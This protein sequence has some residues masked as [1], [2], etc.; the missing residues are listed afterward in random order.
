[1]EDLCASMKRCST[2]SPKDF[3]F[4]TLWDCLPQSQKRESC[5]KQLPRACKSD[6]LKPNA[7]LLKMAHDKLNSKT[8]AK[9]PKKET[10]WNKLLKSANLDTDTQNQIRDLQ[11]MLSN[12]IQY[13]TVLQTIFGILDN[14]KDKAF[15]IEN[16]LY[17]DLYNDILDKR[18]ILNILY[19]ISNNILDK[20]ILENLRKYSETA[21][22]T[23]T[24]EYKQSIFR[25]NLYIKINDKT[26]ERKDVGPII[27][28]LKKFLAD[29]NKLLDEV[30][31]YDE[32][33][34]ENDMEGGSSNIMR[35]YKKYAT[36][37][38]KKQV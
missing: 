3:N 25:K 34:G 11:K 13:G 12:E 2:A 33:I 30:M 19:N 18:E 26:Y 23:T 31:E 9:I 14:N 21:T 4:D 6:Y 37:K 17:T 8:N 29:Q 35:L 7:A 5:R 20:N 22:A 1:M 38:A 27:G 32:I 10:K 28:K 15:I 24:T 16:E 36:P